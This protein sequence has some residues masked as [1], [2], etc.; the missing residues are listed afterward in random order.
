[1]RS[2]ARHSAGSARKR[3]IV[4]TTRSMCSASSAIRSASSGVVA[5]GGLD[6]QVGPRAEQRLG[7]LEPERRR[8]TQ[9][10]D[11]RRALRREQLGH[12]CECAHAPRL[13]RG[14]PLRIRVDARADLELRELRGGLEPVAGDRAVADEHE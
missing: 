13:E 2:A 3:E 6:Q 1:M 12:G 9:N 14:A 5:S 4:S 7:G 8:R 10:C 11:V